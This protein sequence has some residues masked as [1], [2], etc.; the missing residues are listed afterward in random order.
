M[1]NGT[2]HNFIIFFAFA[3]A[4]ASMLAMTTNVFAEFGF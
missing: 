4:V 1:E 3:V 2:L